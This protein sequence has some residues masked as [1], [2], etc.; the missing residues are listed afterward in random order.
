MI[1]LYCRANFF[2]KMVSQ[3]SLAILILIFRYGS[4]MGVLPIKW[5]PSNR[6]FVNTLQNGSRLKFSFLGKSFSINLKKICWISFISGILLFRICLV[7]YGSHKV[8]QRSDSK[9]FNLIEHAYEIS[10]A[11]AVLCTSVSV[12]CIA[13]HVDDLIYQINSV[14]LLNQKLSKK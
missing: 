12:A 1:V 8:M 3:K 9:D 5:D 10:L 4:F 13:F 2:R 14:I 7:L 6:R 11:I